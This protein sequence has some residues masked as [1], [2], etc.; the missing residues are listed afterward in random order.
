MATTRNPVA[1]G[2]ACDPHAPNC[3]IPHSP[4][5]QRVGRRSRSN[6][7]LVFFVVRRTAAIPFSVVG[8]GDLIPVLSKITD[9]KLNGS[10]YLSCQILFECIPVV[11][12]KMIIQLKSLLVMIHSKLGYET[13]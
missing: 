4:T 8:I 3:C 2:P 5:R 9:N 7:H 10:S 1:G 6:D 12:I 11:L 13:I